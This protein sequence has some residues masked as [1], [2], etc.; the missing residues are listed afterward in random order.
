[1]WALAAGGMAGGGIYIALGV[2]IEAAAQ[3]AWLSFLLSGIAAV[4]TSRN[5]ASLTNH[6]H[7]AGGA[8]DFLEEIDRKGWAGDLSWLL[9]IG[10]TLTISVYAYA[11][12][13]YVAHAFGAG[14]IVIRGLSLGIMVIMISLNLAGAGKLTAVEV[15]IVSANLL[16]LLLLAGV[17]LYHWAPEQL[18]AGIDSK[19][20]SHAF[21]GAAAIFVSYEGF[22]L[23]TY[24]YDEMDEPKNWFVKVMLASSA[25]VVFV[26]IA[27]T[28]GA[29]MISGASTMVERKGV[30]LSVA[31][32]QALGIPGLVLMTI[33]AAFATSAAI[34]STLFSTAKLMGRVADDRELP[35]W[36][37]HRNSRNVPDR[38]V[39]L[40]GVI[41]AVL[42]VLGSLSALVEAASLVFVATFVVVN[43]IAAYHLDSYRALSWAGVMLG[44]GLGVTLVFRLF[45]DKPIA[46]AGVVGMAI[47]TVA[48][49]PWILKKLESN[50][51]SH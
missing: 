6:Y 23:L 5:Y 48:F 4:I 18:T 12:G 26:Y 25:F 40:I 21:L 19:P 41:A 44:I 20:L 17:G 47:L 39:I 15:V 30:A 50:R 22:Q 46:L 10:Y 11:F 16:I 51:E 1:V 42:T 38:S 31:A 28:L 14:D 9:C 2:V 3:W 34:N 43:L 27:V 7:S 35:V 45:S 49:R 33:A 13:N 32:E 29:T 24:E 36:F 8:F 37:A